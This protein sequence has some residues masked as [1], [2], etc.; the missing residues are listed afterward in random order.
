MRVV[1]LVLGCCLLS[2]FSRA[3]IPE[4]DKFVVSV[5]RVKRVGD[6]CIA[7]VQSDRVRYQIS[8]DVSGNCAMLSAGEDYRAAVAT[9]RPADSPSDDSKDSSELIIESNRGPKHRLAVFEI[10]LQEARQKK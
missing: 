7:E 6:G 5:V 10:D 4:K 1:Q 8:S 3:Q 2:L 9:S